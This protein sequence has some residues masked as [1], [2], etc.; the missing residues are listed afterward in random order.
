MSVR[1]LEY[2]LQPRSIAVI[3]ASTTPDTVCATVIRNLL[4]SE[5]SGPI[6]PVNPRHEAIAGV[7]S[8]PDVAAFMHRIDYRRSQEILIETPP[9]APAEFAPDVTRVKRIIA[10]NLD[11]G[12]HLLTEPEAKEVLDAYGIPVALKVLSR[13]SSHKSDVGG[14]VLDLADAGDNAPREMLLVAPG[15]HAHPGQA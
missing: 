8:Y 9:S 13:D 7:L 4:Q 10:R 2:L 12:R 3:G 6:L 11:A 14:V 1:N 15:H 5:F